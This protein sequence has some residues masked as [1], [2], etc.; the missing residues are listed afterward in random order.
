MMNP[1]GLLPRIVARVVDLVL[2]AIALEVFHKAGFLAG[3]VYILIADGLFDGR[4]PGKI[5]MR[6]RVLKEDGTPCTVK[7]SILRNITIASG[8]IL[9]KIP[10]IGWILFLTVL[11]F[12][13]VVLFGSDSR[14]RMGDVIAKTFVEEVVREGK[15]RESE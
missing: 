9:W 10:V 3:L 5:L 8:L 7:E 15:L 11:T 13:F 4:S 6:L 12:E 1:A 2:V 14:K